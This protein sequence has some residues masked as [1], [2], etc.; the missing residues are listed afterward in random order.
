MA[1]ENAAERRL[2]NYNTKLAD[3]C[4]LPFE[5]EVYD[6]VFCRLGIMF[7]SDPAKGAGE[8]F[9]VLKPGGRTALTVWNVPAKNEWLATG[10][11]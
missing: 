6:A 2:K 10:K 3:A 1:E 9:R 7:F 8:F 5:D 11:K 4:A